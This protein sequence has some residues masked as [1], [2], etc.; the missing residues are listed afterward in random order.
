M[1]VGWACKRNGGTRT[2]NGHGE[3]PRV[4]IMQ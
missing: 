4:F 2:L 3:T 1:S